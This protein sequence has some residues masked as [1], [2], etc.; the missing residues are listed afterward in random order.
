MLNPAKF[1]KFE[2]KTSN[3]SPF[4]SVIGFEFLPFKIW[5]HSFHS[6][7]PMQNVFSLFF[8][9]EIMINA[10]FTL[11]CFSFYFYLNGV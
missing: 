9:P 11:D 3:E 4:S 10:N 1:K 6:S 7:D 5:K 8:A 2:I